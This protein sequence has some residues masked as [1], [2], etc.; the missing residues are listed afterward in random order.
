[1]PKQKW[2]LVALLAAVL[3]SPNAM[4]LR[5][6]VGTW[7]PYFMN[8]FRTGIGAIVLLPITIRYFHMFRGAVLKKVLIICTAAA[9]VVTANALAL[10]HGPA[11]YFGLI[12]LLSPLI[13]VWFAAR[14]T[15]EHIT[16][17]ALAGI[18]LAAAGALVIVLLPIALSQRQEFVFYPLA[19][20]FALISVVMVPLW[21]VE[22]KM[23][24][25]D[26]SVPIFALLGIG[27]IVAAL[28]SL[29]LWRLIGSGQ[30]PSFHAPAVS[31]VLY[32]ALISAILSR[33]L[34]VKSYEHVGAAVNSSL[35]YVSTLLAILLP[36]VFL[37]ETLS[38]EMV[39]GGS[40]ILLGVF[41]AEHHKSPHHKHHHI[42]TGQ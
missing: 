18:T 26:H 9:T 28:V 4:L 25:Q 30:V 19:T 16:K 14:L 3:V 35:A 37:H 31:A 39:V 41:V 15:H 21:T 8:L 6:T 2:F 10:Q 5:Y 22:S 17:R 36:V 24:N 27:N 29:V 40:L 23:A 33:A 42:L 38:V 11:S 13:L 20:L 34:M 12:A 32:S 1:M 7:D